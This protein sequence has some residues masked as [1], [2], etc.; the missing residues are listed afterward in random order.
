MGIELDMTNRERRAI[1]LFEMVDGP[2][3]WPVLWRIK[4]DTGYSRAG[5]AGDWM[6]MLLSLDPQGDKRLAEAQRLLR[7]WD[8][9]LDGKGRGDALALTIMRPAMRHSYRREA[10]PDPRQQLTLAIDHLAQYFGT[11]D[12]PLGTILRLRQGPEE[13]RMKGTPMIDL[14]LDG[15]SDTLRASTLWNVDPDGRYSVYHGDSF[16]QAIEWDKAGK[17]RSRSIQPFGS[18]TTRPESPYY[19]DQAQ[20]FVDHQTKPVHFDPASLKGHITS[21]KRISNARE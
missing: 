1:E 5:Y 2:I 10:L 12:P 3:T 4:Y 14:P 7:Q 8:W 13:H 18:A 17:V 9:T 6:N 15:G 11:L 19:T 16:I 21:D 20:L